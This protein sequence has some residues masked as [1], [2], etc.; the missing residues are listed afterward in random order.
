MRPILIEKRWRPAM[1]RPAELASCPSLP[2]SPEVRLG[3]D[4]VILQRSTKRWVFRQERTLAL[5]CLHSR[6]PSG[7]VVCTA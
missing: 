5:H 1:A 4:S 7:R 6:K 3:L 2:R